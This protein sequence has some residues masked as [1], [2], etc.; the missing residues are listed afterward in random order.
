MHQAFG[1]APVRRALADHRAVALPDQAVA[2]AAVALLLRPA[3][4]D[5]C[6]LLLIHR[7]EHPEDP[8]SGHMALP[9]GRVDPGEAHALQAAEREVREEV[10]VDLGRCGRLLGALDEVGATARGRRVPLIIAPYVFELTEP[11]DPR[12]NHEVQALYW[13]ALTA[14]CD[15][16][17]ATTRRVRYDGREHLLPGIRVGTEVIWGLTYQMLQRFFALLDDNAR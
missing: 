17:A 7:A 5:D 1:L 8:W 14:L 11:V 15:P 12:P 9:G 10:A 6:E 13:V 16:M 2:R 3:G 4:P